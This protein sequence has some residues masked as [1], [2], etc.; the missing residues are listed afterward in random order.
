MS[1]D[2][3]IG[4]DHGKEAFIAIININVSFIPGRKIIIIFRLEI[5]Q[6]KKGNGYIMGNTV[7]APIGFRIKNIFTVRFLGWT[8]ESKT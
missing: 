7:M 5:F 2:L 8:H 3:V 4:R 6:C 1:I